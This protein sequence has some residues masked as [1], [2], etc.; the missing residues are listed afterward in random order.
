M[1]K[2]TE[3]SRMSNFKKLTEALKIHIIS[4]L[5]PDYYIEDFSHP[6]LIHK[7]RLEI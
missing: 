1:A 6:N 7:L 5:T 2:V 4:H 3:H